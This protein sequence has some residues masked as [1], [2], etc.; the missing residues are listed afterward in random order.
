MSDSLGS[1]CC[2]LEA[3]CDISSTVKTKS[4]STE[5]IASLSAQTPA[6][7]TQPSHTRMLMIATSNKNILGS[8]R[9]PNKINT[10]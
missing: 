2:N 3:R 6:V 9:F 10:F 8:Q 1:C 5:I 4:K 7:D